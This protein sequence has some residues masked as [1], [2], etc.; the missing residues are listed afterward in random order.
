MIISRL[1][2]SLLL[3]LLSSIAAYADQYRS[4]EL[5]I[6]TATST[7]K[8]SIDELEREL[9]SM[10]SNYGKSSTA[11]Y[12]ARHFAD[13]N[14]DKAEKYYRTA[15]LGDGLSD[16]AKQDVLSE[17]AQILLRQKKY[18]QLLQTI[19]QRRNLGGKDTTLLLVA[20][21]MAQYQMQQY[22]LAIASADAIIATEKTPDDI[23][24]KQ[25]LF[26]YYNCNAYN[27]AVHIL[28]RYL[29]FHPEDV[30]SWRQL[31]AIFLKLE[32]KGKAADT[33]S[34]AY[35]KQLPLTEQDLYLLIELYARNGN[36]Y[37]AARFLEQAIQLKQLPA[38]I[39]Y[40]EKL[41]SYWML[42]REHT[43]AIAAL[44]Q[45]LLLQ[46]SIDRYLQLAQLQMETQQWQAMKDTVATA[47]TQA[48][49]D[50]LISHANLLLGIS[51]LKLGNTQAARRA[52][53]NASLVG[54]ETGSDTALG[55]LRY[56]AA[57]PATTQELETFEGICLPAWAKTRAT[58]LAIP[59]MSAQPL[60]GKALPYTI[61]TSAPQ[62]L[63]TGSFT[64]A[65]TE[66]EQKLRPLIM[67]MATYIVKNGGRINGN[68][69]FI[70]TEPVEPGAEV[71]RFQ[72]A[73]PVRQAPQ[74]LGRYHRLNDAGYKSAS[75]VFEGSPEQLPAHWQKL[76][77]A[78][79]ADGKKVNNTSRQVIL[80][81]GA[82]TRKNI[83]ME[84]QLGI[85]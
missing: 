31:A 66:M 14:P 51:E 44:Q 48:L 11:R 5:I 4:Q 34:V 10:K 61:K 85:E 64:L 72:I 84:L 56:M 53:I 6:P 16:I 39:D 65:V 35:Q 24:L 23:L 27:K 57:E 80:G 12:L 67:Q 54:G 42:A 59:A 50:H 33:L 79:I 68:L 76:Y 45:T 62:T 60:H 55:Y 37:A 18:P 73:F 49:P 78:V 2:A 3:L 1:F 71:I 8:K 69:H 9:A 43:R 63:I 52:F 7:V 82:A 17:L 28:Q 41:F 30:A 25:L 58:S 47:C 74:M 46:P 40:Q 21:A 20:Q 81:T 77:A 32:Q 19:E 13:G 36:P 22:A 26:V 70:F 83:K 38:T 29:Q 15:L 75:A